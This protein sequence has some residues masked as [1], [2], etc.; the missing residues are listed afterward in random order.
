MKVVMAIPRLRPLALVAAL[1]VSGV[2][3]GATN[4]VINGSFEQG[5][6]GLGS[7]TGWSTVLGD[8]ATF[9]DSSGQTGPHA[10]EASSGLWSAYFGST[11]A[12]GGALISEVLAT[13]AGQLYALTFDLANDNA[14][15]AASNAI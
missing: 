6:G 7:F 11:A 1:T 3:H 5:A 10:G 4:L 15:F 13:T 2:A 8:A 14:G 12:S 9:V